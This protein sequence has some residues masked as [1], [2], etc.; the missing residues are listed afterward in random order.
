MTS[1]FEQ[2]EDLKIPNEAYPKGADNFIITW[3]F[4]VIS[5]FIRVKFI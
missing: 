4:D 2:L 3:S 1:M 5:Q